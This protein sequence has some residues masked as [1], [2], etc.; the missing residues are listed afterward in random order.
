M[1]ISAFPAASSL[2]TSG[3]AAIA[4]AFSGRPRPRSQSAITG[5]ALWSPDIRRAARSSASASAYRPVRYA[6]IPAASRTAATRPARSRAATA[7]AYAASGS[8]SSSRPAMTRCRLTVCALRLASELSSARTARSSSAPVTS[9][10]SAG[11]TRR[12]VVGSTARRA[13]GRPPE[14]A[15]HRVRGDCPAARCCS[16]RG[17]GTAAASGAA[18][19][20]AAGGRRSGRRAGSRGVS[21]VVGRCRGSVAQRVDRHQ[22]S[23]GNASRATPDG[24][25]LDERMSGGVLLSHAVPRAVPSAL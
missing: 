17:R 7:C 9:S 20:A 6:A 14:G 11:S 10:G 5:S 24:V 25:A 22:T 23:P 13:A 12:G 15:P 2:A 4:S 19:G 16:S 8:S 18:V 21:S 1:S 3:L